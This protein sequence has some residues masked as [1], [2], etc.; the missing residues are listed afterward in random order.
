MHRAD[1]QP[2]PQR[3]PLTGEDVKERVER[4]MMPWTYGGMQVREVDAQAQA[5]TARD[6]RG[7]WVRPRCPNKREG[8]KG[9]RRQWK[10]RNAPHFVMLYREP[11]DVLVIENRIIIATPTQADMLRRATTARAWDTRPGGAW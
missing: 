4:R 7:S 9:T 5:R 1:P 10:R 8:R 2:R 6:V 11:T 3:V